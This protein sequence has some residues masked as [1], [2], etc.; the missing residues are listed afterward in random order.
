MATLIVIVSL[1][2]L[3]DDHFVV[4]FGLREARKRLASQQNGTKKS[5]GT[6]QPVWR[7]KTFEKEILRKQRI[8]RTGS[9][10]RI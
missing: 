1:L 3:F 4:L 7:I 5:A 2:M 9:N 8:E 10:N 6:A